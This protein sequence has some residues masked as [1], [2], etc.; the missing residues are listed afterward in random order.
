[1]AALSAKIERLFEVM[2]RRDQPALSTEAAAAG[3]TARTHVTIDAGYLR[4]L[5][6]G[7]GPEPSTAQLTAIAVF[8]GV[9]PAYLIEDRPDIEDQLTLLEAIRDAPRA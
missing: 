6:A 2:H 8:F 3:I 9:S 7:T 5:R 4:Q 1:M